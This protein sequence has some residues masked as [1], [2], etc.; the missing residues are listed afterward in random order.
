[1]GVF[2]RIVAGEEKGCLVICSNAFE[3]PASC[4][5]ILHAGSGLHCVI[6]EVRLVG[7]KVLTI[8]LNVDRTVDQDG[9]SSVGPAVSKR[10]ADQLNRKVTPR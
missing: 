2:V 9:T 3:Y 6:I 7:S 1:M 4:L 10:W 8:R 5:C